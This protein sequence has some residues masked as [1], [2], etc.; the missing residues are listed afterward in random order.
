MSELEKLKL[1]AEQLRKELSATRNETRA[2][3]QNVAHQL[4][5]PLGAIKWNIDALKDDKI[6]IHRRDNLSRSISSQATILV[7]LI[8]N[9]ALLS[10]LEADKELGQLKEEDEVDLFKLAINIASDFRP[11]AFNQNKRID[12]HDQSFQEILKNKDVRVEKNLIAQALSNLL[13]NAVK[14][15]DAGSTIIVSALKVGGVGVA[16]TSTGIP[17]EQS[18]HQKVF[19]RGY[20]GSKAKQTIAPGTGIGLYLA[21]RIM[22]LHGG[23]IT[24]TTNGRMT[25]FTLVF[26]NSRIV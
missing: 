23:D 20:R 11:L 17:I 16:V 7:H 25:S 1:E 4:T 3:L 15:A 10:N 14:Y 21:K 8:R 26:P 6:P 13:E 5:A 12:I 22:T 9:F 24:L 2:Y 18:E 19:E